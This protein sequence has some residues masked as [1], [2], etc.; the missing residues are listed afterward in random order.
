[1]NKIVVLVV[2]CL[3][4]YSINKVDLKNIAKI[5]FFGF[6]ISCVGKCSELC[7]KVLFVL[8]KSNLKKKLKLKKKS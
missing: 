8:K 7:R 1:M 5:F 2:M 4:K 6:E 3:E